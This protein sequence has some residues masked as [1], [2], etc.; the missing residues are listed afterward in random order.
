MSSQALDTAHLADLR[1]SGLSDEAIEQAGLYSVRPADI[2]K[3][4]EIKTV[5][6]MLAIPY[7]PEF[8]RYKVFPTT[9][10]VQ[11]KKFRYTQPKGSGVHVY[12]PPTARPGLQDAAIAL[13]I[14]EGEK[15]AL[16]ACQEGV[17]CLAIGGLWNWL[18]AGRLT[19]ELKEIHW[20]GRHVTLYP[21]SDVWKRRDLLEA[22]YRLG[23]A[24]EGEGA[25]ITVCALPPGPG[26]TKQGLDDY[27]LHHS[28][29]ALATRPHIPLTDTRFDRA[30]AK[31][32]ARD[33]FGKPTPQARPIILHADQITEKPMQ[34]LWYPYMPR[35]MLMMLDGDPGLGKGLMIVQVATNLSN[36]WPFLD[37]FGKPTLAADV[38]GPQTTLIL[39]AE[40]SLEHVMI[41][42]LTRAGA[43]LKYVKFLTGWI[44]P[45]GGEHAFDLQ[46]L[47][48]LVQAI[49][50]V[51][52]VL[53]VLDPLV[54]YL[55]DID[56]HRSNQTRPVMA[57]L[58]TVAERYGCTIAGVRHPS[59]LDQGGP[60]MYRGQGNMD[61]IGAARSGLWVQKHP[62]HP[63]TQTLMIHSKTNVGMPGRTVIFSREHG[64]F[65]W[66]GVSRL[67]ESM[68]TGKGPD[69]HAFL[70]AFFWLE[71]MM[72]PSIA[73]ESVKIEKEAETRE[74]SHKVLSRAKKALGVTAKQLGVR[75]Y[76]TLPSLS[77]LATT[78]DTGSTEDTG[79]TG[80][81]GY[82]EPISIT[83]GEHEAEYPMH[84]VAPVDPEYPVDPEVIR[85][86]EGGK[87]KR[88]RKDAWVFGRRERGAS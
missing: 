25:H 39:S 74:I 61:I 56:M 51:K 29:D 59:K 21:D 9:L 16:K 80:D 66:K 50:A 3:I 76:C 8:T 7:T 15:K 58:K 48:M 20:Q 79:S 77:T 49:E 73:Y 47:P 87:E 1:K 30:R 35:N 34:W 11:G 4:T 65:A 84:P 33:T 14:V 37:Q 69:P 26:E 68:L 46:H 13:G 5:E 81:T 32:K 6:S 17:M 88:Q 18:D 64:E 43:D 67:T 36:A 23:C 19:P 28:V 54:A 52:P 72:K 63:E 27:L 12:V 41:P 42:R 45:K 86:R 83:Y 10:K 57:D 60:L 31:A 24:L 53:V 55:G 71:E 62:S 38:D 22:V 75:W 2:R 40:E 44:D 78:R 70:D 85:A 82:S